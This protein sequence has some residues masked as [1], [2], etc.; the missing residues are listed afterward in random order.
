MAFFRRAFDVL[1]RGGKFVL[2]PQLWGTYA[3]AKRMDIVGPAR[4]FF[5]F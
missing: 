3:K 1:R 5:A 4:T 2:E